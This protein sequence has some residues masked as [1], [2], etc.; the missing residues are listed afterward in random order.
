[1][2]AWQCLPKPHH[3]AS[4]RRGVSVQIFFF[5]KYTIQTGVGPILMTS[6]KLDYL[7]KEPEKNHL[8]GKQ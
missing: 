4:R 7:H 1:M 5:Y 3:G 6:F 8:E 2:Q